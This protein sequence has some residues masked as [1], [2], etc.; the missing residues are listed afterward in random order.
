VVGLLACGR[1]PWVQ[2]RRYRQRGLIPLAALVRVAILDS[3]ELPTLG[4]LIS[5]LVIGTIVLVLGFADDRFQPAPG[6]RG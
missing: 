3:A 4:R 2:E 1:G 5:V 6:R